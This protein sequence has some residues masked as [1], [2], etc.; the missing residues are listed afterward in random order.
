[1]STPGFNNIRDGLCFPYFSDTPWD[2]ET[3][4]RYHKKSRQGLIVEHH[5]V[6][7]AEVISFTTFVRQTLKVKDKSGKQINVYMYVDN[8]KLFKEDRFK[9]GDS[10]AILYPFQ[11]RFLDGQ[12][13]LRLEEPEHIKVWR[14][15]LTP[16]SLT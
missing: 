10:V 15:S 8:D 3:T 4:S 14:R 5:W 9:A 6:L 13:G 2:H 7:L 1:M 12:H 11:H 16:R